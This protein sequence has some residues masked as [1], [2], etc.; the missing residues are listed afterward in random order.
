MKRHGTVTL[1]RREALQAGGAFAAGALL[2]RFRPATLRYAQQPTAS[3]GDRA[4]EFRAQIAAT[5]LKTEKLSDNLVLL[6]GPGGNV[7]VLTG[8]DGILLVDNFV[9]PAWPKLQE[10]LRALGTVPVK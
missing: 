5:P 8:S 10:A 4:A 2:D 7:V 1:S 6:S 3:Q 9:S